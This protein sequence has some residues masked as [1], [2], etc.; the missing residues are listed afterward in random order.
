MAIPILLNFCI[1]ENLDTKLCK[2]EGNFVKACN[3]DEKPA[4][5]EWLN[6]MQ[7]GATLTNKE[8]LIRIKWILSLV[9]RTKYT[10]PPLSF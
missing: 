7:F 2:I 8:D 4:F 1:L 9:I 6:N 3:G 5:K 10:S